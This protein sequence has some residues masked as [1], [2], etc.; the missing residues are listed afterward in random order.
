M[1]SDKPFIHL[2]QTPGGYYLFDVNTNY[3]LKI[4]GRIYE[5]LWGVL[6][7]KQDIA[8]IE[9]DADIIYLKNNGFLLNKRVSEIAHPAND[10]LKYYLNRK[11]EMATLQITRNCNL[12]CSYCAYSGKYF[13][14][15]HENKTM[16]F[17]T[18]KKAIDFLINH[19]TDTQHISLGFYGGEPLLE[20]DL[21]KKCIEYAEEMAEGKNITF[22]MTT[23]G[24]LLTEEIVD[25]F[26]NHNLNLTISLDGNKEAHDKNR[27]FSAN[28]KGTFDVIM[29][30]IEIIKLKYPD[31]MKKI[32]INIVM[33]TE[34]DFGCINDFF[35]NSD[36]LNDSIMNS[37]YISDNYIKDSYKVEEDF[38]VKRQYETFKM[39]LS[40]IKRLNEQNVSKIISIEYSILKVKMQQEWNIMKNLPDKAH[41]GGPCIAGA[42]RLFIDV[43]GN[44][45]PCERCSE[46]SDVM[47]IGHVDYGFDI[48]KVRNIMN[49]GQLSKENCKN[50]WA[51]R[52]CQLCAASADNITELSK[53]KKL[54]GCTRVKRVLESEL[55]DYCVLRELGHDFDKNTIPVLDM[56]SI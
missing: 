16:T 54:S 52:L 51:F 55:K 14:R 53:E 32:F 33:D 25:Y 18:A 31:Y 11:L 10:T 30:N 44:M 46:T 8:N 29:K 41:P 24:T 48:D 6:K 17:E 4:S 13:N 1:N 26:V 35:F 15:T 20:F 37:T 56:V 23:N 12:R 49:I 43:D 38:I 19:S 22:N 47:K 9:Q 3:I 21:I 27:R 34:N 7:D 45:F 50:C 40:K 28:G 36:I 5:K 2:F 39:Y 42:N